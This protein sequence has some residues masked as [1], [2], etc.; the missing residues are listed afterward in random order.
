MRKT[1]EVITQLAAQGVI[2]DYAIA[3]AVASLYYLEPMLTEDVDVL[4]SIG[5]LGQRSSGLVLLTPIETAL[6]QMGYAERTDVGIRIEGWPVQF[7]P[8]GSDLD[9]A[10]LAEANEIDMDG[11]PPLTVRVLSPEHVVAKAVTIG[12]AKDFARVQAFLA[13]K[14]VDLPKLKA[15]LERFNLVPA[16]S[17]FCFKTGRQNPFLV[18]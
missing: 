3:G 2:K 16:W 6:A 15:L 1:L 11:A 5:G 10:A 18:G 13:E 17:A 8:V 7:L 14:A 4:V 12:R 9:E